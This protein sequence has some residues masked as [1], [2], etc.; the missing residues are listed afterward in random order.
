[1]LGKL[2]C[3]KV[4]FESGHFSVADLETYRE[5]AKTVE[6]KPGRARVEKMR[7]I[8]D[9]G[10][11]AEIREAVRIAEKAF[12]MFRAML[13]PD[14]CE[15]DLPDAMEMYIRRAGGRCSSFPS[16]I[17]GGARSALAHAPPTGRRVNE[18]GVLLV[19]WGASG[20]LY[21]SDLTRVLIPRN[22]SPS[23]GKLEQVYKAVLTAQ[24]QALRSIRAGVKAHDV[25]AAARSVIAEA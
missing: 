8:K 17:A 18:G 21:K 16:I 15:K 23:D 3:R 9:E 20:R 12:A 6:W 4:G 7:A 2:G 5:L 13:R 14:D 22:H 25:D 19:D 10:E 1:V 24:E 11:V